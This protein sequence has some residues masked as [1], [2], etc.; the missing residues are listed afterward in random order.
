MSLFITFEGVEGCGKSTQAKALQQ[1]LCQKGIPVILTH[2]PGG[3]ALGMEIRHTLKKSRPNAPSAVAELFLFTAS[4]A[5]LITEVI[6]PNLKEGKVVLCD[7]FADSTLTYQGYGRGLDLNIIE[8]INTFATMGLKPDLT[9]LLDLP[10]ESG[11]SRRGDKRL[12]RFEQEKLDFHQRVRD[13]YLK[14]A[15]R[16]PERWLIIDATLAKQKIGKIVWEKVS[17]LLSAKGISQKH[18]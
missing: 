13:G 12:D 18:A 11:L 3:T 16:D 6:H 17:Q 4:R 9:I 1:K 15:A 2:E 5:Q 10:V 14:L 7:R 8:T